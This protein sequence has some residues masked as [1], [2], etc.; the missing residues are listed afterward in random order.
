MPSK[1]LNLF[2]TIVILKSNIQVS[3]L[4]QD[5][6]QNSTPSR[7]EFH[8]RNPLS[9]VSRYPL[10]PHITSTLA[11]AAAPAPRLPG[12]GR[13]ISCLYSAGANRC[14]SPCF[15]RPFCCVHQDPSIVVY[16]H[17]TP[18]ERPTSFSSL[19]LLRTREK[20]GNWDRCP[21]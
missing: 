9:R 11:K 5:S 3:T 19:R 15:S 20:V 21:N 4:R 13:A 7:G 1:L 16:F 14:V 6:P 8:H 10:R 2:S 17:M 18:F 12:E